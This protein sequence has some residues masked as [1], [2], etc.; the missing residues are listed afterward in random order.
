MKQRQQRDLCN[1]DIFPNDRF[2]RMIASRFFIFMQLHH[3]LLMIYY[4]AIYH[5]E[6]KEHIKKKKQSCLSKSCAL[7]MAHLYSFQGADEAKVNRPALTVRSSSLSNMST[8]IKHKL[9]IFFLVIF[10]SGEI[11]QFVYFFVRS[12]DKRSLLLA[13]QVCYEC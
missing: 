3:G 8:K 6:K 11:N 5:I 1:Q 2:T 4:I 7:M 13:R 10:L 9:D 12:H